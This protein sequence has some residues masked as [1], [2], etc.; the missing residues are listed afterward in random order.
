MS[1]GDHK[2]FVGFVLAS[3]FAA[4][5]NIGSRI[6]FNRWMPF[7]AAIVVAYI[8]GMI[9]AFVLTR[10]FVFRHAANAL[11]QQAFWFTVVNIAAVIQTLVVSLAL[12]RWLLPAIG[13]HWHVD[14]VAHVCGVAAPVITSF[15]GHK[16]L[17]F[18]TG[19]RR[20]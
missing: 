13:F 7:S 8:C 10:L 9:T 18:P 1:I 17:T 16:H 15:I 12:A 11:H 6:A 2:L 3:G 5:V 19:E 4:L 14:T 20:E